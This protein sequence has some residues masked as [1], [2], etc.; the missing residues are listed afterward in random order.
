MATAFAAAVAWSC[1]VPADAGPL[2][3]PNGS[4]ELPATTY[5]SI[6]ITSWQKSP[7]PPGYVEEGGFLWTQLTGAFKNTPTNSAD[8]I[9]NM[10]GTQA[11]WLFAVPEVALF[12]DYDS[13]G[14]TNTQSTHEFTAQFLPGHSYEMTVGVIGGGGGMLPGVPLQL[15][16]Y[17]RNAASNRVP[18]AQ[19]TVLHSLSNFPA[20]THFQD[21]TLRVPT[22]RASD[23]WANRY[24]GIEFRSTV[25]T[26]MEGGYWD[27]DNVRLV[28]TAEPVLTD[29]V[30][31]GGEFRCRIESEPGLVFDLIT[32]PDLAVPLSGWAGVGT[33]TN[34]TGTMVFNAPM[35]AEPRFYGTRRTP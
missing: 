23:P 29:P 33:V 18:V 26:N 16:L 5:V 7:R 10:E 28:E 3:V 30:Q 34:A 24:L 14:G 8:H 4:F 32:S 9:D 13:V 15:S 22:V 6:N 2:S 21:I 35:G 20:T 31:V 11:I 12:Q 27:L 17:F 1:A 19:A 25:T